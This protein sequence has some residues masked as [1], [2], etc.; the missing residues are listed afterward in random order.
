MPIAPPQHPSEASFYNNQDRLATRHFM[1]VVSVGP[2]EENVTVDRRMSPPRSPSPVD[3]SMKDFS[4][5]LSTGTS[6]FAND[7]VPLKVVDFNAEDV[8]NDR[9][10]SLETQQTSFSSDSKTACEVHVDT[11][12]RS[13][14]LKN[15][16]VLESVVEFCAARD[17]ASPSST[18]AAKESNEESTTDQVDRQSAGSLAA[19]VD[20]S[21]APSAFSVSVAV[22]AFE[23][24]LVAAS[25]SASSFCRSEM[26]SKS[27]SSAS[28]ASNPQTK[29]EDENVDRIDSSKSEKT[30]V[31]TDANPTSAHN[32]ICSPSSEDHLIIDYPLTPKTSSNDAR[33][34]EDDGALPLADVVVLSPSPVKQ[35]LW[36]DVVKSPTTQLNS[37]SPSPSSNGVCDI[38]D[39]LMD[40]ALTL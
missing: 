33:A 32:S 40:A 30:V 7:V 10:R 34:T 24:K 5:D 35:S 9:E 11:G 28:S 37:R 31:R 17:G 36:Q 20:D 25:S 18:T 14:T 6:Y 1:D 15:D 27:S 26:T 4:S 22:S 21:L 16:D 23:N 19:G 8:E 38:E 39:E 29:N 13:L 12:S 2:T 3:D